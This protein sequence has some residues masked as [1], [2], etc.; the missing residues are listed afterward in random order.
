M[1]GCGGKIA[2]VK[3]AQSIPKFAVSLKLLSWITGR[4]RRGDGAV[5]RTQLGRIG[6]A[7]DGINVAAV[8]NE[9]FDN[10]SIEKNIR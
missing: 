6:G 8:L 9:S 10:A 5:E 7:A 4:R 3:M 2:S 1:V